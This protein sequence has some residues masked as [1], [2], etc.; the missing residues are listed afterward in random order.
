MA[1]AARR[2]LA[3]AGHTA[4]V[5]EIDDTG[6]LQAGA[7]FALFADLAGAVRLGADRAGAPR[8]RAEAIGV[9]CARQLLE[10]VQTGATIDRFA[11]DQILPFAA[12]AEGES[13]F[14]IPQLTEQIDTG[15]WPA[16]VFLGA[17][18]E[19]DDRMIAIAGQP[20]QRIT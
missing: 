4:D 8:R 16:E 19:I 2:E 18:V 14:R 15:A 1:E 17:K 10:V 9:R 12:L 20:V 6:A 5:Q 11:A 7:A 3:V 13:R